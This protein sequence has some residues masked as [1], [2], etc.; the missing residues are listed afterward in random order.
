M[1]ESRKRVIAIVAG[2]LVEKQF[3]EEDFRQNG[4]SPRAQFCPFQRLTWPESILR[5]VDGVF[6]NN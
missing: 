3:L 5:H 4:I 1:D 6:G 2:I